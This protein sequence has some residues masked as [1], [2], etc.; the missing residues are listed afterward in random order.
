MKREE[1]GVGHSTLFG[2]QESTKQKRDEY[3]NF[4]ATR[5]EDWNPTT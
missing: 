2:L 4:N 3:E 1:C 5:G